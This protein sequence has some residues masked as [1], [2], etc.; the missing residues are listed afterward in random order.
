MLRWTPGGRRGLWGAAREA[1][2]LPSL[3]A[4]AAERFNPR[5]AFSTQGKAVARCDFVVGLQANPAVEVHRAVGNRF[6]C[7]RAGQAEDQRGYAVQPQRRDRALSGGF[8]SFG[9]AQL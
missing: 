7:L 2:E 4:H 8:R 6:L 1:E 3:A 9:A 5:A